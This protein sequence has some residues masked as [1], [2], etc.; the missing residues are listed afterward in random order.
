VSSFRFANPG[1]R[2]VGV[3]LIPIS[4]LT[5]PVAGVTSRIW[6]ILVDIK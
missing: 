1:L 3:E 5:E 4:S 6:D 2:Q